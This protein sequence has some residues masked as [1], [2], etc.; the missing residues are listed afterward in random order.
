[1]IA[2]ALGKTDSSITGCL[3]RDNCGNPKRKEQ[4]RKHDQDG[5][6]LALERDPDYAYYTV[7][8]PRADLIAS[9]PSTRLR[10]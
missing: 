1:M 6:H 2:Q 8:E 4:Q 7:P 10:S 3:R 9:R 5:S